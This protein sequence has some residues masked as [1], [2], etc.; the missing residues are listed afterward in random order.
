LGL[1]NPWRFSF[2]RS[3]GDLF[4]ADVGQN[5]WEEINFQPADSL[6]AV[7]IMAGTS[8]K[9]RNAMAQGHA[10]QKV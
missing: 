6:L 7:K 2:D 8:W 3:T 9:A 1:R 5:R 10:I 4:I